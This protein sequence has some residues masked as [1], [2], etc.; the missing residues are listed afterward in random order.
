MGGKGNTITKKSDK[1]KLKTF[2][3]IFWIKQ[4]KSKL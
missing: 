4:T 3:Y 1:G 2:W